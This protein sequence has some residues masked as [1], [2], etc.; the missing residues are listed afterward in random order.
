MA[1]RRLARLFTVPYA[2]VQALTL[3]FVSGLWLVFFGEF[4]NFMVI[5]L[6]KEAGPY[7]RISSFSMFLHRAFP[8]R[9]NNDTAFEFKFDHVLIMAIIL[10]VFMMGWAPTRSEIMSK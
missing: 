5:E 10:A 1:G 8:M 6:N 2:F 4:W 9:V 3:L 7:S